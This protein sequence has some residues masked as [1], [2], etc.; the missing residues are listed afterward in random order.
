MKCSQTLL[1]TDKES[2]YFFSDSNDLVRYMSHEL[3][4]E[5]YIKNHNALFLPSNNNSNIDYN[6][7]NIVQKLNIISR[8]D[9]NIYENVHIDKQ[10]G[11]TPIEYYGTFI[12]LYLA[13]YARCVTYGIGYYAVFA[14]KISGTYCK[15]LY[16]TEEW[17]NN[18]NKSINTK[19]CQI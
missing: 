13:I 6:A 3:N 2:I 15:L 11:R 1:N 4:N 7:L 14:T 8:K 10:K 12:D 17:G 9:V 5:T 19:Q 18:Y 16:Q